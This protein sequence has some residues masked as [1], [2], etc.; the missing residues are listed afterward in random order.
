MATAP[1]VRAAAV[2]AGGRRQTPIKMVLTVELG[3]DAQKVI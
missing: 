2:A 1:Q 3:G